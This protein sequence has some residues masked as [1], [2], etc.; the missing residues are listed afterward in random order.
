MEARYEKERLFHD[1]LVESEGARSANRFYAVNVSSWSFYRDLLLA[2]ARRA[3][4]PQILE[5]GSGAGS[6]SA[7]ALAAAG[8]PVVGIDLSAASVQA[9]REHAAREA[10]QGALDYR[11][12]NAEALEFLDRSFDLVCGNGILHHLELE[13]AYAEVAR[14][15]RP[16]GSAVF[17]EPLGHNPLINLYRR[18]TPAQ[19]TE[20]EHPLR[21]SDLDLARRHFGRVEAWYFHLLV[22]AATP[23]SG[24]RVFGPVRRGLDRV[25]RLIFDAVPPSRRLAWQVVLRLS[26]PRAAR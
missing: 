24:T 1:S 25:D 16:D 12:M 4:E 21:M 23:L 11:V 10:P 15:L 14:V 17:S 2:E 7:L 18:L 6:Y 26:Q 8:F 19:R 5:Y 9:A 20:D 3:R 22:L 13:K